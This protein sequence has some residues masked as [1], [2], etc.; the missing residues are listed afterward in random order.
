M[1]YKPKYCCNCS[2][3]IERDNWKLQTSRRFCQLCE[4]EFVSQ[5][6][7]PRLIVL[8][9]VII[10]IVGVA[11]VFQKTEKP[12]KMTAGGLSKNSAPEKKELPNQ[13]S[14]VSIQA[15]SSAQSAAQPSASTADQRRKQ[16]PVSPL[17]TQNA[18]PK[19]AENQLNSAEQ[20]YFCGAATKKSTA[21]LRRVKGGG[22]CWQHVNQP[23]ILP[24][25]KLIASR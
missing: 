11:G 2:E 7:I 1:F 19:A 13:A 15:N 10:S 5:E 22:R 25:D 17:S 20:V 24:P 6:W 14:N 21:C 3:K 8:L 4:T 16:T 9:A 12:L 23:A 18:Q